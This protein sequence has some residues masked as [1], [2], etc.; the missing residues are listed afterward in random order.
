MMFKLSVT[1]VMRNNTEWDP[2]NLQRFHEIWAHLKASSMENFL[3]KC[4]LLVE[5]AKVLCGMFCLLFLCRWGFSEVKCYKKSGG[6]TLIRSLVMIT[7][8]K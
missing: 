5:F 4:E 6:G 2:G 3:K 8:S 1:I 7:N